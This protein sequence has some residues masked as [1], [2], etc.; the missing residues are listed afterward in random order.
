MLSVLYLPHSAILIG[1][2]R[3]TPKISWFESEIEGSLWTS[4]GKREVIETYEDLARIWARSQVTGK[5]AEERNLEAIAHLRTENVA[6]DMLR[7]T[8]AHG[9]EKLQYWGFS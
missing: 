4:A 2:G 7:I 3:T 8:E 9:Y 1:I 5:I 6:Q